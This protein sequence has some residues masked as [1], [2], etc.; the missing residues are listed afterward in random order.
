MRYRRTIA[1]VQLIRRTIAR[2]QLIR[3]YNSIQFRCDWHNRWEGSD[4]R[5]LFPLT[6]LRSKRAVPVGYHQQKHQAVG[7][8][9]QQVSTKLSAENRWSDVSCRLPVRTGPKGEGNR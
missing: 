4:I 1:R 7:R 8:L 9:P 2:V 3:R 5:Q 6:H